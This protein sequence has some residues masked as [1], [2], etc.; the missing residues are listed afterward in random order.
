VYRQNKI[1]T[2][3]QTLSSVHP[4]RKG[5]HIY[6]SVIILYCNKEAEKWGILKQED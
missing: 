2:S 4:E 3:G 1:L 5:L 6:F